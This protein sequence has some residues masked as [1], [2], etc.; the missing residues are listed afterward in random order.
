MD[1]DEIVYFLSQSFNLPTEYFE[2]PALAF[3]FLIPLIALS[4]VFYCFIHYKIRFSNKS[5]VQYVISLV[6]AIF[7]FPV[8]GRVPSNMLVA[9]SFGIIAF[10]GGFFGR[11]GGGFGRFSIVLG[12]LKIILSVGIFFAI[13]WGY[14]YL[15][16]LFI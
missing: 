13:L 7:S 5:V 11:V 14:P 15:Q 2:G 8:I 10:M 16:N 12:F 1:G 9:V 6:I 3:N 4:L